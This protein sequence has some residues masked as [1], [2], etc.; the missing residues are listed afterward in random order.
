M[1]ICILQ[2]KQ[3]KIYVSINVRIIIVNSFKLVKINISYFY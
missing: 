2:F 3:F 1:Q